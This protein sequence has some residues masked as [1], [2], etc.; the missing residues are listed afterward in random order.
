M[1]ASNELRIAVVKRALETSKIRFNSIAV[2]GRTIVAEVRREGVELHVTVQ[3]QPDLVFTHTLRVTRSDD[4]TQ[5]F[6]SL[7]RSL[8]QMDEIRIRGT[9]AL[10]A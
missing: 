3:L 2:R 9:F 4:I 7:L 10:A 1:E 6:V 8:L 5:M